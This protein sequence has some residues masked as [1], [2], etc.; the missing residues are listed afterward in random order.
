[1]TAPVA[2][3][4]DWPAWMLR[5]AKPRRLPTGSLDGGP[6][7]EAPW[8]G[9]GS[10]MRFGPRLGLRGRRT[11]SQAA[12]QMVQEVDA[13]DEAEELAALHADRDVVAAED[14]QQVGERGRR[15][16]RLRLARHGALDLVAEPILMA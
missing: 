3:S 2:G 13:R 11:S 12:A 4:G 9:I 5:V 1:M 7:R 8:G 6:S 15:L 16:D 14:R 10:V